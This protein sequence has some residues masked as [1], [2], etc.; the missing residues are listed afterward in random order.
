MYPLV[1]GEKMNNWE[2]INAVQKMQTYIDSHISEPITLHDLATT[3]GYSP[4]YASRIFKMLTG[5][6]PLS[7]IREVRLTKA[8]IKL[9]QEDARILDV[10]LEFAFNSHEGFT[11]AFSNKFGLSPQNYR[12][13]Q[14]PISLFLPSDIRDYYLMLEKGA[15]KM[16]T[17]NEKVLTPIFIQ[18]VDRPKRRLILKRGKQA[19]DYF[20]YC[21][22]VGCDV[23]GVLCSVVEALYEPI[24]MWL[25]K[26]Y[27][28]NGTSEY[29]Q[30]VEVPHDY[31]GVVP[32]GFEL[33]D[34]PACK[35]MVF[36]GPSFNNEDFEE[37]I[38]DLWTVMKNYDPTLYG[39]KWADDLGPRFQMEPQGERGYIEAR[40]VEPIN[41]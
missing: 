4:W 25:P 20:E 34:L 3:C 22:E 5:K 33:I 28:K 8:A 18:V 19:K 21:D 27:R 36:Q 41:E 1:R 13:D 11:R 40:P 32:E 7:Y 23:W 15:Q 31:D 38:S 24:G 37:A 6:S 39:F 35:V 29:A 14:P 9:R 2:K 30:G 12:R 17:T 10:A 26:K 16:T